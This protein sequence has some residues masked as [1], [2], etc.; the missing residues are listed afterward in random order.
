[1][2]VNGKIELR[3]LQEAGVIF[4]SGWQQ[5]EIGG[6]ILTSST[7]MREITKED[8]QRISESAEEHSASK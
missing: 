2:I 4:D 8:R 5:V 7:K 1:M 3:S 6:R